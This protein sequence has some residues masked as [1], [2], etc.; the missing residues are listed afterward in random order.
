M[1]I[2]LDFDWIFFSDSQNWH[3]IF[4]KGVTYN[5]SDKAF[6]VTNI[7]ETVVLDFYNP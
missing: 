5:A 3:N 2:Y 4:H 1:I 7:L 6:V